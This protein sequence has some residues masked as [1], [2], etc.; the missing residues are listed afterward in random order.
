VRTPQKKV[1]SVFSKKSPKLSKSTRKSRQFTTDGRK[2][3]IDNLLNL[4]DPKQRKRFKDL[5]KIKWE[6]LRRRKD[7]KGDFKKFC[8]SRK[9]IPSQFSSIPDYFWKKYGI[10]FPLNPDYSY[11]QLF[12][13]NKIPG[14]KDFAAF[15]G[16]FMKHSNQSPGYITTLM[17]VR[18]HQLTGTQIGVVYWPCP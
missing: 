8:L 18:G 15:L 1:K 3:R 16:F 6:Y 9:S 11:S 4:H 10:L 17:G 7:Y 12:S 14:T 2:S 13:K 5:S